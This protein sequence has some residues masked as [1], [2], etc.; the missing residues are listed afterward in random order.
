MRNTCLKDGLLGKYL[1][2][3]KNASSN[4]VDL[5]MNELNARTN[6]QTTRFIDFV[7]SRVCTEEGLQR[8]E[9]YLFNGTQ[10]QRNYCTLFYNRK[11]EW[12]PVK[13]AFDMGLIDEIQAFSR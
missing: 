3:A 8:I 9:F 5:I 10:I 2:L 7:L 11:E 13:K 1:A 4:D 6:F 12:K